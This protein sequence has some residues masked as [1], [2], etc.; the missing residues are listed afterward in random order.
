MNLFKYKKVE[1][2][3]LR[4]ELENAIDLTYEQRIDVENILEHYYIV[5][6]SVKEEKCKF[7][8]IVR[9]TLPVFII[10]MAI[11]FLI[12]MPGKWI[13]TGDYSFRHKKLA[14][15]VDKWICCF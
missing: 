3:E 11:L 14:K 6:T 2:F 12:V 5:D 8:F 13:F 10:F 15:F 7:A 4:R 9:L 1:A